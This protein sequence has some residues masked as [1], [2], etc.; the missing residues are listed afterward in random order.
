MNARTRFDKQNFLRGFSSVLEVYPGRQE[1]A[2]EHYQ[3]VRARSTAP[4]TDARQ[5][6][7]D[8]QR[9]GDE[10]QRAIRSHENEPPGCST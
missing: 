2:R 6:Q 1:A 5:M 8:W 3:R 7:N 9:V 10:L 4:N